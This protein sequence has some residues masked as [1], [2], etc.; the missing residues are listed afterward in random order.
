MTIYGLSVIAEAAVASE[1]GFSTF[2]VHYGEPITAVAL[3]VSTF[4]LWWSTARMNHIE[5]MKMTD[6]LSHDNDNMT[7][8]AEKALDEIHTE[9]L[10]ALKRVSRRNRKGGI[11]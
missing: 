8:V 6:A 3:T 4:G 7:H 9:R 11:R 10:H 2:V 5:K 1:N